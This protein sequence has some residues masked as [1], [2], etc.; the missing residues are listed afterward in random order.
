MRKGL[1]YG[2]MSILVLASIAMLVMIFWEPIV[3]FL[4]IDQSGWTQN[5]AGA[6][7]YLDEDGDP[8][9]GWQEVDGNRY[10]FAPN[11][12]MCTGWQKIQ[13]QRHYL[14]TDGVPQG[15][16]Q[17]IGGK[18]FFLEEDGAVVTGWVES[19]QGPVF[20]D[21][22]GNPYAGW[23]DSE[24]GRIFLDNQGLKCTGWLTTK[25]GSFYLDAD[26][27]ITTGW[28]EIDG[29]RYYFGGNGAMTT[30]WL[31][32]ADGL[33]YLNENGTVHTGWLVQ[34]D[35]RY[36]LGQDGRIFSGWLDDGGKRYY[37]REDGTMAQGK[38]VIDGENH[39]F[40]STGAEILLVNRWNVLPEDYTVE[41][42]EFRNG[43]QLT[44]ECHEALMEMLDACEDAGNLT[45]LNLTYRSYS[46]QRELFQKKV[47]QEGSEEAAA[48]TVAAPGTS[49]H[50]TGLAVDILDGH[51]KKLN[52]KQEDTDA[53]KWLRE[54]C[55]EYGFIP[56][57]PS[58]KSDITGNGYEP[59]HYR[60]VGVELAMELRD[61][62]LCL[63]EYLDM[64]TK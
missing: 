44:P 64:L 8:I 15:G 55:W 20:L 34:D 51:Y 5:E 57:Y 45:S 31:D 21:E 19:E 42:V 59:W 47:K 60:Y 32:T 26:G 50:Q 46:R 10:Y 6:F 36:Y 62:N 29:S 49:E 25:E 24:D 58:D 27:L 22:N 18:R 3:D 35:Q 61:L 41:M 63:E 38:V 12:A 7:F 43:H 39:Y 16:W 54:H 28:Q 56:R 4:P 2:I 53:Q 33:Y 1:F 48:K 14:G 17:D 37:I 52:E 30:G 13:Q 9:T 23:L 40:T 11:G